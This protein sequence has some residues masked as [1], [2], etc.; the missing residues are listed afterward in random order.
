MGWS[1]GLKKEK[2][3]NKNC[4]ACN[5]DFAYWAL[6]LLHLIQLLEVLPYWNRFT[7]GEWVSLVKV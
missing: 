3:K 5:K 1:Q 7:L 6:G 2:N 4:I